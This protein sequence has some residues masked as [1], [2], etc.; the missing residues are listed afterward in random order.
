MKSFWIRRLQVY[1]V[2]WKPKKT[3]ALNMGMYS[4]LLSVGNAYLPKRSCCFVMLQLLQKVW[5]KMQQHKSL[6]S[7]WWCTYLNPCS[8]EENWLSLSPWEWLHLDPSSDLQLSSHFLSHFPHLVDIYFSQVSVSVW[9]FQL[10]FPE[11]GHNYMATSCLLNVNYTKE[12]GQC[13]LTH[14]AS[15]ICRE[16]HRNWNKRLKELAFSSLVSCTLLHTLCRRSSIHSDYGANGCMVCCSLSGSTGF[17]L[18]LL[19]ALGSATYHE[20][21]CGFC[22]NDGIWKEHSWP[23]PGWSTWVPVFRQVWVLSHLLCLFVISYGLQI[24]ID[25]HYKMCTPCRLYCYI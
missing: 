23:T 4:L 14:S 18:L 19:R 2:D 24:T 22:R 6:S 8:H 10:Y 21:V 16:R 12:Q 3:K 1:Q 5:P 13:E 9:N 7:F 11:F 20:Y 25:L 17:S 15:E